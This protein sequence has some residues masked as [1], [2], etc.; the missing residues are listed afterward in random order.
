[1]T[2][3]IETAWNNP[4]L[5]ALVWALAVAAMLWW[6]LRRE[7]KRVHDNPLSEP[8]SHVKPLPGPTPKVGIDHHSQ[9]CVDDEGRELCQCGLAEREAAARGGSA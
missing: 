4:A 6:L 1:M 7:V 9:L 8:I 2:L 3:A 5:D